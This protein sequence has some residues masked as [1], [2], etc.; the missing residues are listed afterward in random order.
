VSRA[1]HPG[2]SSRVEYA[3]GGPD[4]GCRFSVELLTPFVVVVSMEYRNH[5]MWCQV[6]GP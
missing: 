2:R 1:K 6:A 3:D 4:L 5:E